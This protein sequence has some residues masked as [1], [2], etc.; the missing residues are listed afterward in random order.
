MYIIIFIV[1][2]VL[3]FSLLIIYKRKLKKETARI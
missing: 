1:N 3:L 2:F